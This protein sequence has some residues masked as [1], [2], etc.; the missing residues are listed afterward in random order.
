M[1]VWR[2]KAR[3]I[4]SRALDEGRA[5][6]LT[7]KDLVAH[8]DKQ[9]PWGE[10]RNHPYAIWLNERALQVFGVKKPMTKSKV[11]PKVVAEGQGELFGGG[12]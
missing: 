8:V 11:K 10:C 2:T 5:I 12:S 4:I 9:Y 7:G 6:G 1:S 3:S